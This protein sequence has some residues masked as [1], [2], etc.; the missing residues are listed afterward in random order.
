MENLQDFYCIIYGQLPIPLDLL[1]GIVPFWAANKDFWFSHKHIEEWDTISADYI[2][3]KEMNMSLLLHYDQIYRHPCHKIQY[4]NKKFAFRFATHIALKM[5]HN[6]QYDA[7]EEWEKV[8]ILLA[9]RH[10]KI[11]RLKEFMLTKLLQLAENN[12]SP[13]LIRFLNATILDIHLFKHGNGYLPEGPDTSIEYNRAIIAPA[14]IIDNYNI[15]SNYKNIYNSVYESI[16]KYDKVAVSISGGVDS[17]VCAIIAA[18]ICSEYGKELILLHINY[19]NRDTCDDECAMLREFARQLRIPLYIRKIT[20]M[21]RVR[22]SSLRTLYEDI[23]RYI[24]FSFYSWFDCP[25]ILGHNLDDCY[26]NVFTNLS[27]RI[28]YDNL[29]GMKECSKE[30]D[31]TILRPMLKIAKKD[32]ILFADHTGTQH[33][34]DSTPAWSQRGKMRDVLI[35]GITQFDTAILPGLSSYIEHTAFLEQ[36]WMQSFNNWIAASDI[37]LEKIII[38]RDEFFNTN[39]MN[40]N[41]WIQLW[42]TLAI[43]NRPSNKSFINLI[44]FIKRNTIYTKCSLNSVWTCIN[45]GTAFELICSTS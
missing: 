44:E 3:T 38:K 26:E 45:R 28:H 37:C 39:Y 23:T 42:K 21:K 30:Q 10:N 12:A 24:R 25:V 43:D 17:M 7:A 33:V 31:V 11:L 2:D 35:P 36:Q 34:Y 9:L 22:S 13:L 32:I 1:N 40:L 6:G 16:K 29:F 27:K 18:Q 19:N 15:E 5:I 20:E 4:D 8:F 41:F 14:T